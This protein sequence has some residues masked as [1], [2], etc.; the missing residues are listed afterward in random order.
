[1]PVFMIGTQRSGSNLLRLMLNQLSHVAAPHPPHVLERM[2]PLMPGYGAL[3][4][5]SSFAQLV[6][7]VCRLVECNPVPWTDVALDRDEVASRCRERSLVA[8]YGAVHDI[9]AQAWGALDWCCKSLAN[10]HFLPEIN[11]YF[12]DARFIYLYR[13]GRDVA[14][15]FRKAFVG[16]KHFYFIARDWDREQRLALQQRDNAGPGR[17]FTVSYEQLTREPEDTLRALCAFLGTDYS[18]AM[19]DFNH[20]HEAVRTAR[21]GA[22]WGNVTRPVMRDNSRRFLQHATEMDIRIFESVAG[23]SLDAL[24]Y[25]RMFVRSGDELQFDSDTIAAF[26]EENR[27]LKETVKSGLDPEELRLRKPQQELLLEIA[28]RAS[29]SFAST[30]VG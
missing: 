4:S 18:D 17:V 14:A 9:M 5:D 30:A 25:E 3:E 12:P 23:A 10:V 7:D 15:S 13:D 24:G 29:T 22:M 6:E 2:A 19:L 27:Q 1:M 11:A 16:E 28:A 21:S 26:A 8:V 20:S